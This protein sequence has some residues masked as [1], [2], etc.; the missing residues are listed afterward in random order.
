M[1]AGRI[2]Q[3]PSP[4]GW[5]VLQ[6]AAGVECKRSLG[7]DRRCDRYCELGWGPPPLACVPPYLNS[8]CFLHCVWPRPEFSVVA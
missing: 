8:V 4:A 7:R 5:E 1:A 3:L 2:R 6:E